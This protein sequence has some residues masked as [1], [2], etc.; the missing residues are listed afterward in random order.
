MRI[1]VTG[2]SGLLGLNLALEAAKEHTVLGLVSRHRLKTD[3]FQIIEGDLLTPGIIEPLL[4]RTQP[5]WVIHCAA[6][7]MLEE[8]E[9]RP[10]LAA[11]LNTEVPRILATLS[12]GAERACCM[13]PRM[14]FLMGSREITPRQIR[15][16]PLSVYARTKLSGEQARGGG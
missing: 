3:A 10:A 9:A 5:D 11:Q 15:T 14:L 12:P 8:C 16:Q 2:A 4:E 6:L 1:L 13:F 7:V